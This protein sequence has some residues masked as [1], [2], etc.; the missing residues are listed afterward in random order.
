MLKEESFVK[1]VKIGSNYQKWTY[2]NYIAGIGK[3]E[4]IPTI[5]GFPGNLSLQI[6]GDP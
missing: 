3:L 1:S 6:C 4:K 5:K 2:F